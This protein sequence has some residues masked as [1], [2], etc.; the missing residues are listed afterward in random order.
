[1]RIRILLLIFIVL[2]IPASAQSAS[3]DD[4]AGA[5]VPQH[6]YLYSLD[7]SYFHLQ[8]RGV[9]GSASF[10]EFDSE[11][12][13]WTIRNALRFTPLVNTE[14][15]LG[16]GKTF[17][18]VYQRLTYD[19]DP[20]TLDFLND[21]R[22][23]QFHEFELDVRHRRGK[24]EYFLESYG[25]DQNASWHSAPGSVEG[26]FFTH[27]DSHYEDIAAGVRLA[28]EKLALQ[29]KVR[30]RAG[31][32]RRTNDFFATS[33]VTR[34]NYF[35]ELRAHV[36]PELVFDFQIR[37]HLKIHSGLAY[38]TPYK[39][40]FEFQQFNPAGTTNFISATYSMSNQIF[41]PMSLEVDVREDFMLRFSSDL[42]VT[43]QRL[44]AYEKETTGLFSNVST[45]KLTYYNWKPTMEMSYL[46]DADK[47]K[48]EDVFAS[49]TKELLQK[50]QFKFSLLLQQDETTLN[51]GTGNGT[52]N[53]I[54]P[55]NNFLYPLDNFVAGSEHSAFLAGNSSSS[56]SNVQPQD[57]FKM[58]AGFLYGVTDALNTEVRFGFQSRSS[59]HQYVFDNTIS[60][61]HY[62]FEP[63]HYVQ[64]ITD[65]QV[66]EESLVSLDM[67]FVPKYKT[68]L[69]TDIHPQEFEV[70]TEYLN[71]TVSFTKLF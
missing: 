23:D 25:N 30:Y 18:Q 32:I 11:P 70:E 61:R 21:Y 3:L 50:N 56:F 48:R 62:I 15:R 64:W 14:V 49:L 54:D 10:G 26:N 40:K 41:I 35:Q 52:Q 69:T 57:F 34:R 24:Y 66:A 7:L 13:Y 33:P 22:V 58:E 27:I 2:L 39:Y 1:M 47:E 45:R 60:N 46:H 4:F 55:Y 5:L 65:W 36:T 19:T 59:V 29:A 63:Y 51:K 53:I 43:K 8:E 67:Y 6:R 38:T 9:H 16:L 68:F 20:S 28:D 12:D 31:K 71:A 42:I 17:S 44:D 37:D